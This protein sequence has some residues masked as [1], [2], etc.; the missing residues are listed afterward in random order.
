MSVQSKK[1]M[2]A[3]LITWTPTTTSTVKCAAE[4]DGGD[5]KNTAV[6]TSGSRRSCPGNRIPYSAK[7]AGRRRATAGWLS[8]SSI[9][10]LQAKLEIENLETRLITQPLLDTENGFVKD[11]D[12]YLSHRGTLELRK[13]ELLHKR[14]TE[15]VWT[16]IQRNI[17]DHISHGH[18]DE[19]ERMRSAILHYI[20]HCNMKG[21]VSLESYD[22]DEY[23]P[24]LHLIHGPR[25][26]KVSTPALKDP[27]LLQSRERARE[28]RAVLRCQTGHVYTRQQMEELLKLNLPG[29]PRS[30]FNGAVGM[31][32]ARAPSGESE[33]I[34]KSNRLQ[35][36]PS[37]LP[38]RMARRRRLCQ[39]AP[40]RKGP[41][42]CCLGSRELRHQR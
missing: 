24:F 13:K 9:G 40:E 8:H 39:T 21:F 25:H 14:W 27:L 10:Q 22:P 41:E 33:S 11:L 1:G 5:W 2:P 38:N 36:S 32:V 7:C 42:P 26:F 6:S 4:A 29:V 16:P 19:A 23:D 34:W 28:M 3:G 37:S 31:P 35:D 20:E 12:S 18:G 17:R 15:R 30:C